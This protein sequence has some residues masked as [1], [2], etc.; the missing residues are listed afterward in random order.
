VIGIGR[1]FPIF[2]SLAEA[3]ASPPHGTAPVFRPRHDSLAVSR[4]ALAAR[5]AQRT[6]RHGSWVITIT[7]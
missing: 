3:L 7:P 2:T 5:A 4:S 1:L 6:G